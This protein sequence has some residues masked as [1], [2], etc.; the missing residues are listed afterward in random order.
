MNLCTQIF[1]RNNTSVNQ[2]ISPAWRSSKLLLKVLGGNVAGGGAS[3]ELFPF[4][5]QRIYATTEVTY[6][7]G[8]REWLQFLPAV[9]VKKNQGHDLQING[10]KVTLSLSYPKQ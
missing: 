8:E 7:F 3:H 9:I 2:Q 1:I 5:L 10:T 6:R 4:F